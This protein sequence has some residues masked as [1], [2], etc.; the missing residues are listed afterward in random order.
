MGFSAHVE[1]MKNMINVGVQVKVRS[2]YRSKSV[3]YK[4]LCSDFM[5]NV[6]PETVNVA[7]STRSISFSSSIQSSKTSNNT[8]NFSVS[9]KSDSS[10][11]L[12]S[13]GSKSNFSDE[14]LE[15]NVKNTT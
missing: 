11:V 8:N 3:M 10:F 5:C 14:L 7:C 9:G 12:S 4:P 6:K 1:K 15:E 13:G 2:H